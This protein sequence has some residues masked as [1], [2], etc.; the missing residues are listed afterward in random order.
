VRAIYYFQSRAGIVYML[1]ITPR[2]K[3]DLTAADKRELRAI[4]SI[5]EEAQ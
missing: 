5:I 3:G 4:V 1:D 2:T